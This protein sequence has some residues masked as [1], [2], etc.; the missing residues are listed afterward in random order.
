VPLTTGWQT[1]EYPLQLTQSESAA[2]LLFSN[3]ANGTDTF[4]FDNI[5]LV[6]G[7]TLGLLP[8]ENLDSA[9]I[10]IF[11]KSSLAARTA[12]AQRDWISFLWQLEQAYWDEMKN[13]LKQELGYQGIVVG[14]IVGTSTANLMASL[15]AVDTHAYWQHPTFDVSWGS[16][17]QIRNISMLGE[18]GGTLTGLA[19]RRVFGK[20]HTVTEYNTGFPNSFG[21]ETYPLLAAYAAFQDW[22][23]IYAF[24]YHDADG[25]TETIGGFFDAGTDPT[26]IL[27][28]W[29]AALLFRR[30][31]VAPGGILAVTPLDRQTEIDKLRSA[32]AW[33]LVDA[34]HVGSPGTAPLLRRVALLTEGLTAP[35]GSVFTTNL[36]VPSN[37][38]Y[39]AEGGQLRWDT[40]AGVLTLDSPRSKAVMGK[41][42]G[43]EYRLGEIT[44]R[45][46]DSDQGYSVIHLH[47]IDG[48]T[49]ARHAR[50]AVVT[51]VGWAAN[52][53]MQFVEYPSTLVSGT[54]PPEGIALGLADPNDFGREP[55]IAEGIGADIVLPY[56]PST[57]TAYALDGRGD[58]KLAVP[59]G[60]E[61]GQALLQL[62]ETYETLWYEIV[63]R[64][65][66]PRRGV[67]RRSPR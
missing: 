48:D 10:R 29:N 1:F 32:G 24:A 25:D 34:T 63:I 11:E 15:D 4:W 52:S 38:I 36:S 35:P 12:V 22:D 43:Q 51:A 13:Y 64:Q 42:D 50:T 47:L 20:P 33:S 67:R 28:L 5:S 6:E 18:N 7:G 65:S 40:T 37:G 46:T 30:G 31:D 27:G 17:W 2:R 56:P 55:V 58:R 21:A 59:V 62:S 60:D 39:D 61:E 9:S 26:R 49:L 57:V 23:G 3:L 8:G 19:N 66:W 45:P 14:S 16:P 41:S 53:N 54:P 44:I